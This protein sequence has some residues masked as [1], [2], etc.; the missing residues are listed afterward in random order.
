MNF[1]KFLFSARGGGKRGGIRTRFA[2]SPTGLF[3]VGSARTALF[4]FLFARRYGGKFILRIEDT[5]LE[6]SKSEYEKD[7][8]ESIKWLGLN[9]DEGVEIGGPYAPY[10]Q[11]QRLDIYK[12]Y[13]K[14][15]FKDG[16]VFYCFHSK[17]FLDKEYEEQINVKINPAHHCEFRKL[18]FD[19]AQ[20]RLKHENAIIRFKTPPNLEIVFE[21]LIRGRISFNSDT[22]GGDFSL[23]KALN[24]KEF[25]PL[26][27]FAVVIDDFEMKISHVIRGEEH[28]SNTPKQILIQRALNIPAPKYAHL[29]LILGPDKSKLSK[30]HGATSM[31]DYRNM[32]YL[33]EA[34]VNYFA[35]LGWNP[36]NE[37]EVFSLDEL[38]KSF[39]L[40]KVQKSGA[41]FNMEKLDWFNGYYLRRLSLDELTKRIIPFLEK[42]G[43]IRKDFSAQGGPASDWE[44]IKKI[45]L[46][47]QPRL[48]RL[49]EVGDKAAYF[50]E[51]PQYRPELLVWRGMLFKEVVTSLNISY[52]AL[53]K[54]NES[55]FNKKN[56]EAVLLKEAERG[57]GKDKG[58]LLWPLRAALT[59]LEAS[60]GPFEILEI[61]GKNESLKRVETAIKKLA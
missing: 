22:L 51:T 47:E 43:L 25:S 53:G 1:L 19:A 13:I 7:F 36:G 57:R 40:E 5:D 28:I 52:E 15:L 14:E 3:H 38:T 37:R 26:Y 59:G 31:I 18:P 23:A 27:N 6:R 61:L 41:I 17:E 20:K 32:G 9:W 29:P 24:P 21:D 10:R 42:D 16:D 8:S 35:F 33:P 48:K 58:R 55:D 30:R 54:V 12:K 46:L 4:N 44:Y 50:F 34:L 39:S 11:S 60:P 56:L 45:V 49:C 2:P